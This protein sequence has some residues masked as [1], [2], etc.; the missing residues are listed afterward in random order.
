MS[1]AKG[2]LDQMRGDCDGLIGWQRVGSGKLWRKLR[3]HISNREG[4]LLSPAARGKW[5]PARRPRLQHGGAARY[6]ALSCLE[7][8]STKRT[9]RGHFHSKWAAHGN[10]QASVG[11]RLG[12]RRAWFH[13]C[14]CACGL[15][16][17]VALLKKA[18]DGKWHRRVG[19]W[20]DCWEVISTYVIW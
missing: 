3:E 4:C 9:R 11:F 2:G 14:R 1:I 20:G 17:V 6:F 7:Q 12:W 18:A 15:A 10:R 5:R 8:R 19:A 16:L 13:E